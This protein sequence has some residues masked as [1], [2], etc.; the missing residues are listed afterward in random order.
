MTVR[1]VSRAEEY[2]SQ[3]SGGLD[4]RRKS[5]EPKLSDLKIALCLHQ[6]VPYDKLR[7]YMGHDKQISRKIKPA[8][9]ITIALN[10]AHHLCTSTKPILTGEL[11]HSAI[12]NHRCVPYVCMH[13]GQIPRSSVNFRVICCL[14]HHLHGFDRIVERKGAVASDITA[15]TSIR[16]VP[17]MVWTTP[18]RP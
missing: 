11:R 17:R 4:V 5:D 18:P 6:R 13:A 16:Y 14:I 7:K 8:F 12:S 2:R 9:A 3:D 15:A 1:L 10:W